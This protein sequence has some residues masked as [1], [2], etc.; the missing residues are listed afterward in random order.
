MVV[1]T[2]M[3]NRRNDQEAMQ[4]SSKGMTNGTKKYGHQKEE[5]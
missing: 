4:S 1:R 2:Q 5:Q 3:V